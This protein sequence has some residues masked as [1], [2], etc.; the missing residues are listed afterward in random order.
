MNYWVLLLLVCGL[1]GPARAQPG[2]GATPLRLLFR[3]GRVVLVAGDTLDGPVALQFGPDLLY[4]AQPDGSVRT[5]APA[6]VAACAVQQEMGA[7]SS[8]AG[9]DPTQ[10]R[11]FRSLAWSA[12]PGRSRP[13]MAFFEQLGD[14]PVLLLRRQY[15]AQRLVAYAAPPA[16]VGPGGFRGPGGDS[17]RG[18][19]PPTPPRYLSLT[20]LRDSF[21]L[22]RAPGDLASLP[23]TLKEVLAAFPGQAPQLHAYAKAHRLALHAARDLAD[24]VGYANSLAGRAAP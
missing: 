18:L 24:L 20:D 15:L 8:P 9:A 7:P 2:A 10:V 22:A 12:D 14:G 16:P 1:S 21:F 6:T 4:L 13:E 5:F 19:P 23:P 11:L 17:R 3:L